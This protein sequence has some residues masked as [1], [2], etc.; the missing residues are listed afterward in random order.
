M[1]PQPIITE[2]P[3]V[4]TE[5]DYLCPVYPCGSI[6]SFQIHSNW[7]DRSFFGLDSIRLLDMNGCV[8][9]CRKRDVHFLTYKRDPSGKFVDYKDEENVENGHSYNLFC[10]KK[11]WK[12]P[13][14]PKRKESGIQGSVYVAFQTPIIISCIKVW[15]FL[16]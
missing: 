1:L 14:F 2:Q 8:I 3:F 11:P 4:V 6:I 16:S 10:F 7:G 13:I 15:C 5:Q 12:S 9:D